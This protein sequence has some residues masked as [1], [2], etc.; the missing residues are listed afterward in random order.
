MPAK[1]LFWIEFTGGGLAG[2][3][4]DDSDN[5]GFFTCVIETE[6]DPT[7]EFGGRPEIGDAVRFRLANV[8]GTFV[9][10]IVEIAIFFFLISFRNL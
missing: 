10:V 2:F 1:I 3:D 9:S 8:P 7:I 6:L 4:G 5:F